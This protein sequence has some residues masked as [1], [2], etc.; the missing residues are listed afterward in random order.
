MACAAAAVLAQTPAL[1]PPAKPKNLQVLPKDLSTAQV[2]EKMRIIAA[3]L[4]VKCDFCHV[5]GGFNKDD[6]DTKQIARR[7][8]RMVDAINKDNFSGRPEVS[9]YTCHRG[10]PR[11][12]SQ[13][14]A[15]KADK[16]GR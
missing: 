7:M 10:Q 16:E 13:L 9:C 3:S 12:A 11:P 5:A 4:G 8:L 14:P 1:P 2:V 15:G 6:K